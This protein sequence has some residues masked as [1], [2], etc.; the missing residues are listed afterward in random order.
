MEESSSTGKQKK[1]SEQSSSSTAVVSNDPLDF[2]S[3]IVYLLKKRRPNETAELR[4]LREACQTHPEIV[5]RFV[6][7]IAVEDR[8]PWL[9]GVPTVVTLPSY[10]ISTGSEAIKKIMKW[11]SKRPTGTEAMSHSGSVIS[12]PLQMPGDLI[13]PEERENETVVSSCSSIEELLRRRESLGEGPQRG[14]V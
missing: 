10:A 6:D 1:P 7:E 13:P 5:T 11:C 14:R 9:R 8:P 12:A 2:A 3:F 4:A